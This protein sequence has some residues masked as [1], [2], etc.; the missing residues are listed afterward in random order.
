ML[1]LRITYINALSS[2]LPAFPPNSPNSICFFVF[3]SSL[4]YSRVPS[5]T[6]PTQIDSSH[7]DG[8][9][10]YEG[11]NH[12]PSSPALPETNQG[13]DTNANC[14]WPL[15]ACLVCDKVFLRNPYPNLAEELELNSSIHQSQEECPSRDNSADTASIFGQL[16]VRLTICQAGLLPTW[17]DVPVAF[18]TQLKY[19]RRLEFARTEALHVQTKF[20]LLEAI[21]DLTLVTTVPWEK[22][23]LV[24]P[25]C[26]NGED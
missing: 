25:N 24:P 26:K 3:S 19:T 7:K 21:P 8:K 5:L 4:A 20:L 14:P 16:P 9:A 6:Q 10:Y 23:D 12:F 18:Y 1:Y 13:Q 11:L 22:K 2:N 15:L 17:W